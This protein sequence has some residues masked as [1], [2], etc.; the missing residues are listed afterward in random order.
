MYYK[1]IRILLIA[2]VLVMLSGCGIFGAPFDNNEYA[3]YARLHA[4][5]T[6]ATEHCTNFDALRSDIDDMSEEVEFLHVYTKHL[7]YNDE[8]Y[9]IALLLRQNVK[10]LK[11]AYT[12]QNKSKTYCIYKLKLL[13]Q[14]IDRAL[15]A[16]S[17]KVK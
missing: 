12:T 1:Q 7:S 10:E 3:A 15:E 13:S 16:V 8:S 11:A 9:N 14:Q 2:T 4:Q 6:I 17:A 5:T